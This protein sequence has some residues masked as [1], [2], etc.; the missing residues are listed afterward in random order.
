MHLPKELRIKVARARLVN[1]KPEVHHDGFV[2]Q[3]AFHGEPEKDLPSLK[4]FKA[5]SERSYLEALIR[6]TGGDIP[7]M[8]AISELSRSHLYALLKKYE[9][10]V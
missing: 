4:A 10:E 2:L 8:L 9:L 6:K 7:R 1:G 5:A 3:E